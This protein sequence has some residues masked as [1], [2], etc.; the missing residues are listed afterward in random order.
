MKHTQASTITSIAG[1]P[2]RNVYTK[3]IF[4]QYSYMLISWFDEKEICQNH[5]KNTQLWCIFTL[6]ILWLA[7]HYQIWCHGQVLPEV[8]QLSYHMAG[9]H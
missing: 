9:M 5:L 3:E 7:H 4:N 2:H 8:E 1:D 6:T